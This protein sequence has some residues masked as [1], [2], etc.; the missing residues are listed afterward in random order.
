EREIFPNTALEVRYVGN[1][2]VKVWRA[3]DINEINIFS[4]GF[5][6]EFL[7]AKNNY[8]IYVA[9]NPNCGVA[10]NP[11]N[12]CRFGNSG[13]PGQVNLPI[14]SGFFTGL[15]A[16]SGSGFASSTFIN[17]LLANN[18]GTMANTLAFSPTYRTNREC[19]PGPTNP[20]C[21]GIAANY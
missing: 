9:T 19:V 12:P 6:Q 4:N 15:S 5:L 14:L 16:T 17:N 13:L 11:A 7:N 8:N 3:T 18:I 1:H 10:G 21:I 20:N 2:A